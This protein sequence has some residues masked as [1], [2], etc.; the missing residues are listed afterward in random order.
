M[1]AR[2]RKKSLVGYIYSCEF[3]KVL[4]W[5]DGEWIGIDEDVMPFKH[6]RAENKD[7]KI[8][9][10]G[11]KHPITKVRITIEELK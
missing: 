5:Q 9:G 8:C 4:Y 3:S 2:K 6:K 7:D 11:K 10:C 1:T